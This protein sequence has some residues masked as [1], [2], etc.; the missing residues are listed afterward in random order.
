[1][2]TQ[3]LSRP[4]PLPR[5][6]VGFLCTLVLVVG[7]D[8]TPAAEATPP[9]A[10]AA[11]AGAAPAE[12]VAQTA[13]EVP[14]D[15]YPSLPFVLLTPPERVRFVALTEAELCPCEG[16]PSSLDACLQQ[17]RPCILAL[18]SA[19][20]TMRM[21]KEQASDV[22]ISDALGQHVTNARRVH[23][24]D[25]SQTPW[26]GAAE[27]ALVLVEFAD[28]Q[29]PHCRQV[30]NIVGQ[31]ATEFGDQIRV[32]Y[33]HFPLSSHGNA[34]RASIAS[35]A[36]QNQD[37]FW[38]YHD[39]VFANQQQLGREQDPTGL[40]LGFAESLGLNM[41]R[42]RQDMAD[43][44]LER[45]VMADRQEGIAAGIAATPTLYLDGV[46]VTERYE[47]DAL[48]ALLRQRLQTR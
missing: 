29:C 34:L 18:T 3:P 16:A 12:A 9:A 26:K 28:F 5:L 42:F 23:T 48:T 38:A 7:C 44:A 31:L 14:V 13:A 39:L 37:A 11:A 6:L 35:R 8:R 15:R 47:H 33:K 4:S 2:R 40:L 46:L 1:M 21:I 32:Y 45:L 36:A 17:E 24:F 22:E 19:E 43:P 27:P 20:L 10:P 30:S 25:L 41:D